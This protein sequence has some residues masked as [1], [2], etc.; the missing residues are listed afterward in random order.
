MASFFRVRRNSD[1]ESVGGKMSRGRRIVNYSPYARPSPSPAPAASSSSQSTEI[2]KNG[3]F[4]G[5]VVPASRMIASGAGKIVST[6]FGSQDSHSSSDND[7][8]GDDDE[9]IDSID[10]SDSDDNNDHI[11]QRSDGINQNTIES[12]GTKFLERQPLAVAQRSESKLQIERLLMQETFSR[13]ECNRL[14]KIIQSRV[15]ESHASREGGNASRGAAQ[16]GEEGRK[17]NSYLGYGVDSLSSGPLALHYAAIMESK[18]WLEEKK[19][20]SSPKLENSPLALTA[21]PSN[22]YINVTEGEVGSPVLMAKTYMRSRP[23]WASP[24]SSHVGFRTPS[25]IRM[26]LVKEE[27]PISDRSVFSS[28]FS[29]RSPLANDS[30]EILAELRRVRLKS[31]EAMLLSDSSIYIQTSASES[32]HKDGRTASRDG[33]HSNVELTTKSIDSAAMM[34]END[35]LAIE[36]TSSVP[37]VI[38]SNENQD[39]EDPRFKESV[40]ETARVNNTSEVEYRDDSKLP[41]GSS[42]LK[43]IDG[44]TERITANGAPPLASSLSAGLNVGPE[45]EGSSESRLGIGL[46][47]LEE[48]TCEPLSKAS[49]E[50]PSDNDEEIDSGATGPDTSS[51]RHLI[52]NEPTSRKL[53]RTL[54]GKQLQEEKKIGKY[55]RRGR[56]RGKSQA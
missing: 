13:D 24:S 11:S 36:I 7:S 8:D 18:K 14:T 31:E 37:A 52:E 33:E 22:K 55:S 3:W 35:G 56:G 16:F 34:M 44:T 29:R 39:L 42:P 38:L 26:P 2:T 12:H 54:V 5:F 30:Q 51:S 41:G 4:S 45:N 9:D 50:I 46:M 10:E 32:G 49:V 40:E 23:P 53:N 19:S 27:T 43:E 6:V 25:P 1:N 28:K 48:E 21:S 15:V 17:S 20:E 47:P